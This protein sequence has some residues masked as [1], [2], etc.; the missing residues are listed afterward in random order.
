MTVATLHDPN[1]RCN[2]FRTYLGNFDNYMKQNDGSIEKNPFWDFSLKFYNQNNIA[3]SCIALQ[4]NVG[5]DVNIL[6]YCCWVASEGAAVIKPAEFNEIIEALEPW[7][8]SVVQALRQIRRDMKRHK[9]LSLGKMSEDLR[10]SIKVCELE[11]EKL[12]QVI[13]YQ[14]GQR[15]FIGDSVQSPKKIDNAKNNL[16]NYIRIISGSI[17]ETTENLIQKIS[18]DLMGDTSL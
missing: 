6:L 8:S 1:T 2:R 18:E 17:L 4:D 15:L 14:S 5:A 11:S 7:Q 13:L 9:M 10:Q 3:S 12:E 16:R